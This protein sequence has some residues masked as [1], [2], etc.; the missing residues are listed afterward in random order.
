M[1]HLYPS[2][3]VFVG[4]CTVFRLSMRACVCPSVT[5]CFLNIFDGIS[6][7]LAYAFISTGQIFIISQRTNGL[8][9]AHL[10]SG[11]RISI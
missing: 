2:Q 7:N 4:G 8:V 11:P 1:F 10:I 5:F 3:T 9:N 6:S